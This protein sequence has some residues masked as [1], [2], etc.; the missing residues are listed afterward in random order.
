MRLNN[1]SITLGGLR[2]GSIRGYLGVSENESAS[3]ILR[4]RGCCGS[5]FG[6]P[7][8]LAEIGCRPVAL[9]LRLSPDLPLSSGTDL[10]YW[11][12]KGVQAFTRARNK[13]AWDVGAPSERTLTPL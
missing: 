10:F 12:L 5:A 2:P 3:R 8:I 1:A 13:L 11:L 6:S 4:S 9:R 7:A